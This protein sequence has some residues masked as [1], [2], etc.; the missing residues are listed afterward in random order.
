MTC[1]A[2]TNPADLDPR[3]ADRH[4][5]EWV[6]PCN[7]CG[8]SGQYSY[9]PMHGSRC[10]GCGGSGVTYLFGK[11]AT[12]LRSYIRARREP[13]AAQLEIGDTVAVYADSCNLAHRKV[14]GTRWATVTGVEP[15]GREV[16]WQI[17]DGERVATAWELQVTV[18]VDGEARTVT[19]GGNRIVR[20]ALADID[21]DQFLPLISAR[22]RRR[23]GI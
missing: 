8:G 4:P 13:T 10:Y 15:T 21:K 1:D 14:A 9:N 5:V 23:F 20:R 12:A 17:V 16:G 11:A 19:A 6:K 18:E 3:N 22:D 7:R 2:T